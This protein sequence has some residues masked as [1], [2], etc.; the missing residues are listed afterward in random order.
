MNP[1]YAGEIL[2]VTGKSATGASV[3][4]NINLFGRLFVAQLIEVFRVRI[5]Q[6]KFR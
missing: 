5:M 1:G 6:A 3:R 2:S 4:K